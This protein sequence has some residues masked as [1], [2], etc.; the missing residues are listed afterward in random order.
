VTRAHIEFWTNEGSEASGEAAFAWAIR[1]G[2]ATDR[3]AMKWR[4]ATAPARYFN[5]SRGE[6]RMLKYELVVEVP[7]HPKTMMGNN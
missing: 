5:T 6:L 3:T 1:V 7:D 2:L 4:K